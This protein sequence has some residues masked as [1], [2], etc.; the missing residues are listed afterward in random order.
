MP[1]ATTDNGYVTS[2]WVAKYHV[3]VDTILLDH[4]YALLRNTNYL[5]SNIWYDTLTLKITSQ[6]PSLGR[7]TNI[8]SIKKA[9]KPDPVKT[10]RPSKFN[11]RGDLSPY[12]QLKVKKK[13]TRNYSLQLD[14]DHSIVT[15]GYGLFAFL[16][17]RIKL[18]YK[19]IPTALIVFVYV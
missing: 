12:Q 14:L 11:P 10:L 6:N 16:R 17:V 18:K 5:H 1:P 9:N 15:F 2:H 8:E 13:T 4:C 19:S 7:K 3:L